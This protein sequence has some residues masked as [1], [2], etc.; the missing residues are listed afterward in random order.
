M[1]ISFLFYTFSTK[2]DKNGEIFLLEDPQKHVV[3]RIAS[4]LQIECVGFIFTHLPRE[5]FFSPKDLIRAA[6]YDVLVFVYI[7]DY[8]LYLQRNTDFN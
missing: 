8:F 7:H 5:D 1:L 3:D 2:V 6:K 4:A